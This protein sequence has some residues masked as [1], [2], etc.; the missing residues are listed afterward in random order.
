MEVEYND[1]KKGIDEL[2]ELIKQSQSEFEKLRAYITLGNSYILLAEYEE[3]R[4]NIINALISFDEA[5]KIAE[6]FSNK[7][8][9]AEI[10][11]QKGYVFYK[12]AFLEDREYNLEKAVEH[13]DKSIEY[14]RGLP[15]EVSK[16][17]KVKYNLANAYL[18][19]RGNNQK[20]SILKGIEE[21]NEI[22]SY[23]NIDEE[24]LSLAKSALGV[25][26]LLYAKSN[27]DNS[28]ENLRKSKLYFNEASE[29]FLK[30]GEKIDYAA[31][32]N[33]LGSV[34]LE[35]AILNENPTDNLQEA[36]WHFKRNLSIYTIDERPFDYGS[37]HYNIGLA[38]LNLTRFSKEDKKENLLETVSH[39][40]KALD[41]YSESFS[42]EEY[43]RIN[44]QKGVAYRELFILEH[45]RSYLEQEVESLKNTLKII[46]RES[47]PFTYITAQFFL[48]EANYFMENVS[49]SLSHYEEA[50]NVAERH[51]QN[52]GKQISEVIEIIKKN[53]R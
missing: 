3:E 8:D 6:G 28:I 14:L 30:R 44:Y 34:C 27:G 43:A 49:E 26:Y 1:L 50:L 42:K 19:T 45:M 40:D 31:C 29:S 12:L 36:I 35:L 47:N 39:F 20:E 38:Y 33:G 18:A 15:E 2:K 41:V 21:L 9:L 17:I 25:G 16:L 7:Q 48:G 22:L 11:M 5:L 13:F 37:T 53:E 52:L 51:D 46:D 4:A 10:E 32:E 24:T 23:E